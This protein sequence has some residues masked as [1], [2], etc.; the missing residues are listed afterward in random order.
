MAATASLAELALATEQQVNEHLTKAF[1]LNTLG[2]VED[3][4]ASTEALVVCARLNA[5]MI[6]LA[7]FQNSVL[8]R[9][10]GSM[11]WGVNPDY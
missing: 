4:G 9:T 7:Q 11:S 10:N 1:N 6:L 3:T 8:N 5:A 2:V